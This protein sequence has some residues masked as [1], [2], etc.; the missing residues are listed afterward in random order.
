MALHWGEA[1]EWEVAEWY[2]QGRT[3]WTLEYIRSL[4]I[5]DIVKGLSYWRGLAKIEEVD[6]SNQETWARGR[7]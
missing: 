5:G 3:G 1:M 6:R 4:D 7:K 2:I